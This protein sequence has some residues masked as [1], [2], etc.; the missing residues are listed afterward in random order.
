L[1]ISSTSDVALTLNGQRRTFYFT[2]SYNVLG[3]TT[4]AYAAEPG[5]FGA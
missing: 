1:E 5:M 4:P 3:I 2:P